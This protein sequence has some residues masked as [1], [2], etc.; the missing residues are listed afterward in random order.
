MSI[1][2]GSSNESCFRN[3]I[4]GA[5]T[6]PPPP[7]INK[8]QEL[9][10]QYAPVKSSQQQRVLST[11]RSHNRQVVLSRKRIGKGPYAVS[12]DDDESSAPPSLA[13]PQPRRRET[14]RRA[15]SESSNSTHSTQKTRSLEPGQEGT[16]KPEIDEYELRTAI[17]ETIKS[18]QIVPDH[19]LPLAINETFQNMKMNRQQKQNFPP[20]VK[21]TIERH[22]PPDEIR[23]FYQQDDLSSDQQFT[24]VKGYLLNTTALATTALASLHI[25]KIG[26]K[27]LH[28]KMKEFVSNPNNR[29][30]F[31]EVGQYIRGTFL[32]SP[33]F[34]LGSNIA[35]VF[36][37]AHECEMKERRHLP[38]VEEEVDDNDDH[39]P[40]VVSMES[41]IS[42]FKKRNG[43]FLDTV[44]SSILKK[45]PTT[46]TP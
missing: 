40:P 23:K 43:N 27:Y 2:G 41:T 26:T 44:P 14:P 13:S 8:H 3:C 10:H 37:D 33:V 19:I 24:K 16:P 38:D 21:T 34:S 9:L 11:K 7:P 42:D 22:M 1:D 20:I 35:G 25:D 6:T 17:E 12:D 29:P 4:D 31:D 39:V 46:D 18:M 45:K 28:E 15:R 30:S 5:N 32:D 36:R